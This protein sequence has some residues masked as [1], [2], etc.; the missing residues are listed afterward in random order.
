MFAGTGGANQF[1][2]P[3]LDDVGKFPQVLG[4][5]AHVHEQFVDGFRIDVK[6]LV[7]A[8]GDA[9]DRVQGFAKFLDG[10]ADVLAI[11]SYHGVNF[12]QGFVGLVRGLLEVVE[13]GPELGAGAVH[14]VQSGLDDRAILAQHALQIGD[15]GGN[16]GAVLIVEQIVDPGN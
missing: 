10:S 11:L 2:R 16:V 15:A 6:S 3:S 9:G 8:A 13:H 4:N 14:I 12:F 1:G 5:I 7:A